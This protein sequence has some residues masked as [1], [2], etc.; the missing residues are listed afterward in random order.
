MEMILHPLRKIYEIESNC[1]VLRSHGW[2]CFRF[3]CPR[4]FL[5]LGACWSGCCDQRTAA[6]TCHCY[7]T[8]ASSGGCDSTANGKDNDCCDHDSSDGSKSDGCC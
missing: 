8:G 5:F 1:F 3:E 2:S 6:A 4:A 7:G